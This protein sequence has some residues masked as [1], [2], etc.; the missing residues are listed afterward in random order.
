MH[1][2]RLDEIL[3][4]EVLGASPVRIIVPICVID[5]L[6]NKKGGVRNPV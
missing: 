3:W 4:V 1:Y 6:D 2:Q 5:E